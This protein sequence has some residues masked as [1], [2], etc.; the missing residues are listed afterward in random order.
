MH[1]D[2]ID[3]SIKY[4]QPA[5]D[6]FDASVRELVTTIRHELQHCA[7]TVSSLVTSGTFNKQYGL[8]SETTSPFESGKYDA[9]GLAIDMDVIRPL[10]PHEVREDLTYGKDPHEEQAI[11][12]Q[13][14]LRDVEY[15]TR[16]ADDVDAFKKIMRSIPTGLRSRAV[17]IW[18]AELNEPLFPFSNAQTWN[19]YKESNNV[20]VEFILEFLDTYKVHLPNLKN[21]VTNKINKD[22]TLPVSASGLKKELELTNM[23]NALV[24][25]SSFFK[26]LKQAVGDGKD[27]TTSRWAK[28]AGSFVKEVM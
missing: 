3:A 16:L 20:S 9:S 25:P 10:Q 12:L 26:A 27:M 6:M 19:K 17:K 14:P 15:Q 21:H 1:N 22:K 8:P 13:H 24:P 11:L 4:G 23:I 5:T 7:Q 18:T 28:A 2:P